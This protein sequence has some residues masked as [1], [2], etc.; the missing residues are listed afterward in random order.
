[1]NAKQWLGMY[2]VGILLLMGAVAGI[3]WHIDPFFHYHAPYTEEYFYILDNERS[4]NM[5]IAKHFE[6]DAIITGTSMAENFKTTEMEELYS[7][8]AVKL[9]CSG[10]TFK[11]IDELVEA[12]ISHQD[13]I[14]MVV[15]TM[16]V[17]KL[18]D[19]AELMRSDL[20][21]Y[22]T[23]LYNRNPFDDIKYL[24][25][26]DIVFGRC[27]NMMQQKRQGVDGG[28]TSFDVYGRWQDGYR[29]GK[30][31]VLQN[32]KSFSAPES[33]N[34]FSDLDGERLHNNIEKNIIK[35]AVENPETAF[36]IC[37]PPYS[38]AWWGIQYESGNLDRVLEAEKT[39]LLRLLEV[40]NIYVYS[41]NT[42]EE[43]TCN[44][45]NYKDTSH[46]GEHINSLML[47]EIKDG[48]ARLTKQNID[49]YLEKERELYETYPYN[50]LF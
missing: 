11:E 43:I 37:I 48:T 14:K 16:D 4:Q 32:R 49:V 41:W 28:V 44:L 26:R 30:E 33:I 24:W 27:Y 45:D 2:A 10:G 35:L 13:H 19:D 42:R 50:S 15:R 39:A 29:F 25:N 12:A 21:T 7:V 36:H 18:F 22:P 46:Y 8:N 5:G 38:V 47:K 17:E 34:V 23:Y 20:G 31:Y 9:T 40:E 3:V 6:F 1:M